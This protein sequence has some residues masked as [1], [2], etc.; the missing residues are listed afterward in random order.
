[1]IGTTLRQFQAFSGEV[2]MDAT[3]NITQISFLP[4]GEFNS[5][6]NQTFRICD[7]RSGETGREFIL[8]RSGNFILD[9]EYPSCP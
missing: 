2:E 9:R 8:N 4:T 5:G 6:S 3:G 7:S 1:E